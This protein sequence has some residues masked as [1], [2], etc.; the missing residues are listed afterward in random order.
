MQTKAVFSGFLDFILFK[1]T[2]GDGGG[3]LMLGR[4]NHLGLFQERILWSQ[5]VSDLS[6]QG[7]PHVLNVSEC[8][9]VS[10]GYH[11][12]PFKEVGK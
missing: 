2:G 6:S 10:Q 8:S 1:V 9:S 3:G 11:F 5:W 7:T 12:A 4:G